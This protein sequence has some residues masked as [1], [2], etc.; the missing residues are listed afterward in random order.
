MTDNRAGEIEYIVHKKLAFISVL[1]PYDYSGSLLC[2]Q[3]I[4]KTLV[5]ELI[6]LHLAQHENGLNLTTEEQAV[7]SLASGFVSLRR[8]WPDPNEV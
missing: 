4:E 2:T 8:F 3:D 5:H 7:E 1:D 6:H